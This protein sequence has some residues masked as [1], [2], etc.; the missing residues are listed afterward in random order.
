TEGGCCRT[1]E[2]MPPQ[3]RRL[4]ALEFLEMTDFQAFQSV[5][6]DMVLCRDVMVTMRDGVRLATDIYRPAREGRALDRPA[7]AI[8][9]RTPYG[10]A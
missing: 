7:P 9:E 4:I 5:T 3:R 6:D 10:K 2:R 1:Q 8:I